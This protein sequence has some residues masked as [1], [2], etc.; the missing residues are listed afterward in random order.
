MYLTFYV[1]P[2]IIKVSENGNA[3][4]PQT[5]LY[6]TIQ[7]YGKYITVDCSYFNNNV[8]F[9]IKEKNEASKFLIDKLVE[10]GNFKKYTDY[11][12]YTESTYIK[13]TNGYGNVLM[14]IIKQ[15][16]NENHIDIKFINTNKIARKK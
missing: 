7:P 15:I 9:F 10:D 6:K 8:Y 16:A 4:Y 11:G 2:Y 12:V 3:L 14:D 13:I 1:I 5:L